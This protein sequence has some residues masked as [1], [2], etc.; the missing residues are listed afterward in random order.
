MRR[1]AGSDTAGTCAVIA[2]VTYNFPI[3]YFLSK[4]IVARAALDNDRLGASTGTLGILK[5]RLVAGFPGRQI[6]QH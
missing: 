3:P 4:L 5:P 2:A 6:C 1:K